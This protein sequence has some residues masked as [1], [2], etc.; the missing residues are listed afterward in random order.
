MPVA[1]AGAR[2]GQ[3]QATQGA[4][5]TPIYPPSH[6]RA[7]DSRRRRDSRSRIRTRF[8]HSPW[9]C[10]WR[11]TPPARSRAM[12]L[13]LWV[14][15]GKRRQP[16][17]P[18]TLPSTRALRTRSRAIPA[19]AALTRTSSKPAAHAPALASPVPPCL[20][21]VRRHLPGLHHAMGARAGADRVGAGP[22]RVLSVPLAWEVAPRSG[23]R[24]P[25]GQDKG[26]RAQIPIAAE[27]SRPFCV[28]R[29]LLSKPN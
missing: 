13:G 8:A 6:P 25:G 10:A 20:P 11:R 3:Q 17:I 5:A 7:R 9:T 14:S 1:G 23:H 22:G 29:F 26:D 4:A 12:G 2:T 19:T 15:C 18:N 24:V 27:R 16:W 21:W 28:L